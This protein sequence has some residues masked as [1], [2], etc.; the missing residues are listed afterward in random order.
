MPQELSYA[1]RY[2]ISGNTLTLTD[3]QDRTATFGKAAEVPDAV[4]SELLEPTLSVALNLPVDVAYASNLLSDGTRLWVVG[5]DRQAYP[6]DPETG[7][8]GAGQTLTASTSYFHAVTMQGGDFWAHCNCGGSQDVKRMRLGGSEI[9]AVDTNADLHNDIS[10][11]AGAWDGSRLWLWGRNRVSG[12]RELLSV[13]SDVEPDGLDSVFA[14]DTDTLHRLTYHDGAL[15]GLFH[16]AGWQ[17]AELDPAAGRVARNYTLPV[18]GVE[19]SY[20]GI[21][22]LNGKLY[23]LGRVGD[24]YKLI[25]VQP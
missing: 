3:S 1:Y 4:R 11:S 16:F 14:F 20:L 22:S 7:A 19:D 9:D 5:E 15:W 2:E 23:L 21:A 25:A 17:V 12:H 24:G 13:D 6:I 10:I 18:L 8:V